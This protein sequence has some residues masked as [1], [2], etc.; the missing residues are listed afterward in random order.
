MGTIT[1]HVFDI[2]DKEDFLRVR[3]ELSSE[4]RLGGSELGTAVGDNKYKSPYALWCEK[5]GVYE[6]G[7][8]SEREATKQGVM[9]EDGVAKRFTQETGRKV[10][11]PGYILTNSDAPHLFASPD[12]LLEDGESGLECKTAKEIVM[13]KFPHGDFPASY[14]DQCVCYLKVTEL[15]RW[16]LA[17]AVYST[18][19][20]IYMMTTDKREFDRWEYFR[21]K[22][23]GMDA[24]TDE[25]QAEWDK[26]FSFL[27]ACYYIDDEA[28][29]ACE[30]AAANFMARVEAG[31]NG[32]LDI[33]P[34]EE[35]DGSSSTK[36]AIEAVFPQ[37]KPASIVTFDSTDEYG[38][39]DDG[40]IYNKITGAEITR[41][42]ERHA[43]YKDA[44]EA[45]ED[46]LDKVDNLIMTKMQDKETFLIP[47]WKVTYKNKSGARKVSVSD[48]EAYFAA[49]GKSVP[50]GIIKTG[51]DYRGL[52][53]YRRK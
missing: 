31:N 20:N 21:N 25:E 6:P 49:E 28:L 12:R 39:Q 35:I 22:R 40:E 46:E 3:N 17:I 48:V 23:E 32:N 8:P 30:Q 34:E 1:K 53:F 18:S 41:L 36:K 27:E 45:L 9:F 14:Y 13:K 16:Y 26:N 7:D 33:W 29:L 15:K 4:G 2:E 37:A 42:V 43:E 47:N 50:D 5:I 11:A 24:L 51:Q 44:I 38:I 52:N 19:F 10:Y